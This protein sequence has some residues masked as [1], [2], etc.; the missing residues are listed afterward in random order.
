ME[1]LLTRALYETETTG[2]W[3]GH[4]E[5]EEFGRLVA[6][7]V[8]AYV[9]AAVE[10]ARREG[11]ETALR[12]VLALAN[13]WEE[14]WREK[15]SRFSGVFAADALRAAAEADHTDQGGDS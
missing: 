13:E 6:P 14:S 12:P 15:G 8:A 4:P 5:C 10:T 9:A 1:A 2:G 3:W 11:A 7:K